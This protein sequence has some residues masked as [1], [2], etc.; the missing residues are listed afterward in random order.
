MLPSEDIY[1]D[2]KLP[3]MISA[4]FKSLEVLPVDGK[5]SLDLGEKSNMLSK[6]N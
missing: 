6:L 2:L 5:I 4:E 1:R 3:E